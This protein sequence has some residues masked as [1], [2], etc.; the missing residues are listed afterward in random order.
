MHKECIRHKEHVNVD[1]SK[2][3]KIEQ[4]EAKFAYIVCYLSSK[5]SHVGLPLK[6]CIVHI[7]LS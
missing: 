7:S 5:L 2:C 6:K 4:K 1:Y 3:K